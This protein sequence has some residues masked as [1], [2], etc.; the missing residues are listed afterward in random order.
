MSVSFKSVVEASRDEVFAWHERPGAFARLA[1]P[2]VPVTVE[3]EAA[4]LRDGRAVLSVAGL[5]RWVAQHEPEAYQRPVSFADRLASAPWGLVHWHHSHLFGAPSAETTE[6]EDWVDTNI[7]EV[8]LREMFAYRQRQLAGDMAAHAR[9]G[10]MRAGP[11]TVAMTGSSGSIGTALRSFLT[12]GGHRV[13]RLVRRAPDGRDERHWD[14]LAPSPR[15]FDGVDAVVHLAGKNIAGRFSEAHKR[16]LVASRVGPTRRLAE[17]AAKAKSTGSGLESFISASAVGYYGPDR[18]DEILTER[19]ERGDGF[20]ADLVAGWEAAVEPAADGGLRSAI[21]RTG[22]VQSPR[23]GMLKIFYPLYLAGLGG[24]VGTGRQWVPWVGID[25]VVDIYLRLLVDPALRGPVN[26]VAPNAVTNK[27]YA[28]TLGRVLRRPAV[29][30]VPSFA[31]A[32]ILK[33]EGAGEFA[34][35][36]QRAEPAVLQ[37]CGHQFRHPELEKAF[38]HLLGKWLK[39]AGRPA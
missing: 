7:P 30:A 3:A 25:D 34:L 14:V 27:E 2:W 13:V 8:A 17:A 10:P 4:N 9:A 19:S 18:G 29:L 22:I 31:P 32:L 39:D 36:G 35:A 38:R 33:K 12:T 26:A 37:A 24:P 21:V 5:W 20:L 28:A 1:P 23:G 16:E 6:V 11:M 15:M